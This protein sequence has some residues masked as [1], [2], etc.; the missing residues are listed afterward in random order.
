[1]CGIFGTWGN[2]HAAG[3]EMALSLLGHRGPDSADTYS[4]GSAGLHL[5]HTRLAIQDLSP[6]G[7]QPMFGSSERYV[8]VYN[9]EIYNV[10]E[11]RA[12]LEAQGQSFRGNSDSEVLLYLFERYGSEMLSRLNGIFAFAIWDSKEQELFVARDGLGVK[13]LYYTQTEEG[14]AFSSEI[15][16][17]PL[18]N[19]DEGDIDVASVHRYLSYAW[20]PGN[21]TAF[22][23]VQ[24]L[25][26]GHA[27]ILKNGQVSRH[28]QWY[29]LPAFT[30][31][32]TV[33]MTEVEAVT[34]THDHL[35]QAVER[36]MISDAPLGAFLSGG[37]DSSAVVA[38]ARQY[39]PHI[40]CFTIKTLGQA[41]AGR[42]DDYPFAERAA[43]HLGVKLHA[44]EISPHTL[45]D[46][47][48]FMIYH[49]DEPIADAAALNAFF[50]SK[51]ARDNGIKVLL[52]GAGGDDLFT[53]YPRH[54]AQKI[55]KLWTWMPGPARKALHHLAKSLPAKPSLLRRISKVL[56]PAHLSK[57][58][59]LLHYFQFL[60]EDIFT[61][62]YTEEARQVVQHSPA[63][64]PMMEFLDDL[65]VTTSD[66]ERLLALEQRFFLS[67]HNLIYTDKMSMAAGVEA[68]VP[69]LDP[70][71][72]AFAH[73]VPAHYKM[74][75]KELK[76]V[77]KKA[78]EPYLPHDIIYRPKTGFGAPIRQW[79]RHDL[80]QITEDIIAS[81][82]F[83]ARGI[84][85]PGKVQNL[86]K[87]NSEGRIDAAMPLF[88]IL[89]FEMWCRIFID[90]RAA[91]KTSSD[92]S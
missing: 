85:E 71:L 90:Q 29:Q 80:R 42:V 66:L 91:C 75:G 49:L 73:T 51:L 5:G 54:I 17:L 33:P 11:L 27:M 7:A 26:P 30:Q 6:Q 12:A 53:G 36:Q 34:G 23:Q 43:A 40:D 70:D 67:D 81:R 22:K 84:F 69:F 88:A 65:P 68:R 45:A 60:D 64:A 50:I 78:M 61:A 18:E 41:E 83:A 14:F 72:V 15:K 82:S 76:W 8:L 74:R 37:L 13:P 47:L 56:Q 10:R 62:L 55:E 58:Q 32:A 25:A 57:D 16:A 3:L 48:E 59:R 63:C 86:M 35:K 21:G 28:W 9:G 77:L 52:S 89:V 19:M 44:V 4:D 31:K 39:N 1:M 2:E 92:H 38:F 87:Q 24:K 79:M 20:C 46:H